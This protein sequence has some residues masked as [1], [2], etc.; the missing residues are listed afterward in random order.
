MKLK[1]R[2]YL[3]MCLI[4]SIGF[5]NANTVSGKVKYN[6]KKPKPK[7]LNMSADAMCGKM[8]SGPVYNESFVLDKEGYMKNVIVWIKNAPKTSVPKSP[9]TL[10]QVGCQYKPHVT[11]I[12]KGQN[13]VIKNSDKTIHNIHSM[14]DKNSNFNFAM[15]INSDDRIKSFSKTE[16]PF[17][18]K[19]DVHPWMKSWVF[20][21][22][23]KYWATTNRNGEYSIDLTGLKPG[24]YD[25]CFW[26]EKWDKTMQ[27]TGYCSEKYSQSITIT[28][29]GDVTANYSFTK[30][31]KKK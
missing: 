20:V 2:N 30:P 1:Q 19:C 21:L 25:L 31:K 4:L 9:V 22:E 3:V 18:I 29:D 27:K 24:T 13:L 26:Q 6:G 28:K 7:K 5:L 15:P 23:H 16:D 17:Y 12:M 11:G 14:A 8:H 10:D